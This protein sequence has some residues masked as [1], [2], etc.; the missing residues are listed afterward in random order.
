MKALLSC[1]GSIMPF[2]LYDAVKALLICP[3]SIKL[4]GRW[5]LAVAQ[6]DVALFPTRENRP[7]F[8][9]PFFGGVGS[10]GGR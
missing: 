3:G 1:L 2:G 10:S 6:E 5:E 7:E 8:F 4:L 9:F